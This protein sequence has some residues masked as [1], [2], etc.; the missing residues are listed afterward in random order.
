MRSSG[1]ISAIAEAAARARAAAEREKEE[2]E[3]VVQRN[4][5]NEVENGTN[6][7]GTQGNGTNEVKREDEIQTDTGI[8]TRNKTF[9]VSHWDK[10]KNI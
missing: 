9:K 2:G 1:G 3:E 5:V 10:I 8:G 6:E 7:V 4:G